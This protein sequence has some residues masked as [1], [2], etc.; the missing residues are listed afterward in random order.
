MYMIDWYD[1]NQCHSNDPKAHD[2]SNGRIF[3]IVYGDTK[4]TKV[5]VAKLSDAELVKLQLHKNDW[6][7]RTA[8]RVLQER[9]AQGKLT[10]EANNGLLEILRDNPEESRKLRAM[11]ALHC[12][13]GLTPALLLEQLHSEQPYVVAWAIQFLCEEKSPSAEAVREFARLAKE[14]PS[15]VVRLYLAS[16]LQR[17]PAEQRWEVISGLLSHAEDADDHNLPLMDWYALEPLCALDADRALALAAQSKLPRMLSF[18]V[19]RIS[20]NEGEV[21]PRLVKALWRAQDTEAAGGNSERDSREP[22]RPAGGGNAG[23]VEGD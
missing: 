11:W 22:A 4:T 10:P 12:T 2:Q 1:K 7:V 8:R 21:I 13:G 16:A 3:K 18:A 14:S 6:Y 20:S 17:T 9:Q 23:G 19:R 5:D 15:A